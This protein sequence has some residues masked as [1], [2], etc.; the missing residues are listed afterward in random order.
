M[1]VTRA[2]KALT[3]MKWQL[4]WLREKRS[5]AGHRWHETD[6]AREVGFTE[7][8]DILRAHGARLITEAS[9]RD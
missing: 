8:M 3:D 1:R 5:P 7:A 4:D 6:L 2:D 9:T